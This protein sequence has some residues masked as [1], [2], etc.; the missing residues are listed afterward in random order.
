MILK[1]E[2]NEIVCTLINNVFRFQRNCFSL[3]DLNNIEIYDTLLNC[4]EEYQ[5]L[6]KTYIVE[7]Y[8]CQDNQI[9]L[10]LILTKLNNVLIFKNEIYDLNLSYALPLNKEKKVLQFVIKNLDLCLQNKQIVFLPNS[11]LYSYSK[12]NFD[13][14]NSIYISE[15][16][17]IKKNKDVHIYETIFSEKFFEFWKEFDENRFNEIQTI[18]F[19]NFFKFLYNVLDFKIYKYVIDQ[20]TIA[21]NVCYFSEENKIIYDVLFPWVYDKKTFRIGIFAIIK[22][23]EKCSEMQWGYS[24]CY[25]KFPYKDKILNKLEKSL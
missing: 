4:L 18:E 14:L 3:Q 20:T 7:N 13:E 19:R 9:I 23:L 24:L 22:N 12:V 8:E 10:L 21:Y 25:G 17:T 16:R 2:K 15:K 11:S 6:D 1:N 5:Y